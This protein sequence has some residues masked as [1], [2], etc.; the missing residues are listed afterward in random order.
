MKQTSSYFDPKPSEELLFSLPLP[1]F[2]FALRFCSN[3]PPAPF[4]SFSKL[5]HAIEDDVHVAQ[6]VHAPPFLEH[7]NQRFEQPDDLAPVQGDQ[8]AGWPRKGLRLRYLYALDGLI[9]LA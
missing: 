9:A 4:T 5:E 6:Q 3:L 8:Q 2:Q 7:F 1:P